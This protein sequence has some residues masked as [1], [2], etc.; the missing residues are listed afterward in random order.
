MSSLSIEEAV[1]KY[2]EMLYRLAFAKTGNSHDAQDI[3]QET[4]LKLVRSQKTFNDEEHRKAWLIRVTVNAGKNLNLSAHKRR[5]VGDDGNRPEAGKNDENLSLIET[6]A[7]VYPAVMALPEK[8]R[9]IIHL[10]YYEDMQIEQICRVTG[11]GRNTVK[12]RLHRAR[13]L[14]KEELEEVDF[15]EY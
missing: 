8:Y 3:V 7:V 6:K 9:T 5:N 13:A 10:F 11:L 1:H 12:S 14:L 4:F 15:N 2:S